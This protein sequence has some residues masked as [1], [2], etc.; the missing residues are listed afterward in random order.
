MQAPAP[1]KPITPPLLIA[2]QPNFNTGLLVALVGVGVVYAVLLHLFHTITTS[3]FWDAVIGVI[4]G[5]Y[6]CS[7]PVA[8]LMDMLYLQNIRW[9]DL[10]KRAGMTWLIMN[11]VTTFTGWATIV[12]GAT[13]MVRPEWW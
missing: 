3:N 6:I 2:P 13:R 8:N 12:L 11:F 9:R 1:Q 7:R 10:Q 5:I 4:A